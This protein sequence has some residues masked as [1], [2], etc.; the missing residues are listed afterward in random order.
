M[1]DKL[2]EGRNAMTIDR[3]GGIDP[4][5]NVNSTQKPHRVSG[6]APSDSISLSS[7]AKELSEVYSAMEAANSAPDVRADKVAA[8]MEKMKDPNYINDSVVDLVA[9][10]LMDVFGV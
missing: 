5:K 2:V 4:L 6:T 10:R 3:L 7:E 1:T 9:D 8:V